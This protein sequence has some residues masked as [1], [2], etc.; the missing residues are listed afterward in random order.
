MAGYANVFKMG[1]ANNQLTLSMIHS[2]N[3][4]VQVFDM[5]G[6]MVVSQRLA[7]SGNAV[8]PMNNLRQGNYMVR[9]ID[10]SAVRTAR[11]A[12]K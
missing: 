6:N 2:S 12:I 3:V 8:V 1:F 4:S 7:V 10:G 5:M 11:I 9:V